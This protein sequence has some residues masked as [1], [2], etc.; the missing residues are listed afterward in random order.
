MVSFHALHVLL[1]MPQ[2][3]LQRNCHIGPLRGA[4]PN[5]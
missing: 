4:Y 3:R 5:G 2:G 1:H